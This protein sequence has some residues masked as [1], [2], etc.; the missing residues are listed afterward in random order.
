MLERNLIHS[1]KL[2][3]F[4]KVKPLIVVRERA[5]FSSYLGNLNDIFSGIREKN[6]RIKQT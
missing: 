3:T 5:K 1:L 6:F 4:I 2:E